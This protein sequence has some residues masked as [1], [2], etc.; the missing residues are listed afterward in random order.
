MSPEDIYKD[1]CVAGVVSLSVSD[2]GIGP[3]YVPDDTFS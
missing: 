1:H 3:G 2:S